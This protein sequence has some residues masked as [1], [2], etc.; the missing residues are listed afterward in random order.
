MD[1]AGGRVQHQHPSCTGEKPR[2]QIL[3]P[4]PI[5]IRTELRSE[6][7]V[8]VSEVPDCAGQMD[9]AECAGV[10]GVKVMCRFRPLSDSERSRVDR[11]IPKFSG[12]DT[13]VLSVSTDPTEPPDRRGT[14]SSPAA[15]R[16]RVHYN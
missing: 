4:G 15:V 10:C 6:R 3:V 8:V 14:P 1:P 13:V 2:D 7:T 16:A 11:F 9:A 5:L 12:D